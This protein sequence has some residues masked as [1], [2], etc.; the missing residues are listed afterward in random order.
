MTGAQSV[1][2]DSSLLLALPVAAVAGLLSFFTPCSLPL[3][4]G[5][6]SYVAGMSGMS[7]ASIQ[8]PA[9]TGRAGPDGVAPSGRRRRVVIGASLFVAGFAAVFTAYGALFGALGAQ[10]IAHQDTLVRGTGLLTI[11]LG[12]LF[13]GVAGQL[14]GLRRTV[15]PSM[16][17]RVGLAGAPVLGAVFGIG[18]TP[19]IGPALAAVLT[20]ATTSATAGRGAVLTLAYAL[21]LGVPFILA[22]VWFGRALRVFAWAR[23]R[24]VLLTRAGGLMLV[25]VGLL[26][27]TGV[28]TSMVAGLQVLVSSWQAPL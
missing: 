14:P 21:G 19:C 4:P 23:T 3:V 1:I 18:W 28:W 11:L 15:R 6:L 17:P 7:G 2:L 25:A 26:Q 27:V 20:L 13:T 9:A 24:T 22:A 16:M 12:V 5:Y 10:L 8:A